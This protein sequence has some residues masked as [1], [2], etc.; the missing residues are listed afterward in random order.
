[1]SKSDRTT[2]KNSHRESSSLLLVVGPCDR[3][4]V[5]A[6]LKAKGI[7]RRFD[8]EECHGITR[9]KEAFK[10]RL[11]ATNTLKRLWVMA[12]A[13]TD[14]SRIWQALRNVL[15]DNGKYA[16]NS[17][18]PLP[19]CGAIY[20]SSDNPGIEVG[21][22][23]MPDNHSPGMTE[24]FI[25]AITHR[26][27]TLIGPASEIVNK[28]DEN[29]HLYPGIFRHCHK[30]KAEILTWLAWQD[31]PG[32]SLAIAIEGKRLDLTSNLCDAFTEWLVRLQPNESLL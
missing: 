26:D 4:V 27:D 2:D 32:C 24:N 29:R 3:M 28:L 5:D 6:L 8:I 23:I 25:S 12:D 18:S 1:M 30:P 20:Q 21:I 9:L 19:E 31:E 15:T 16:I 7:S 17:K 13:D 14:C 10:V 22:W 11:K